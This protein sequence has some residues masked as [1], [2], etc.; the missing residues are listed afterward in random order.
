LHSLAVGFFV[1]GL[2]LLIFGIIFDM[3]RL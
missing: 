2:S 3:E 1:L